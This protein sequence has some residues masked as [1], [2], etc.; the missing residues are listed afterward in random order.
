MYTAE[1][2]SGPLSEVPPLPQIAQAAGPQQNPYSASTPSMARRA[3]MAAISASAR[4]PLSQ[5][6]S[7]SPSI[8]SPYSGPSQMSPAPRHQL[9]Q[10]LQSTGY[11]PGSSFGVP[12]QAEEASQAGPA[13][14]EGPYMT[15]LPESLFHRGAQSGGQNPNIRFMPISTEHGP[16]YVPVDVQAA[17]KMA[18]EKRARNAGASARFRERRKQKEKEASMNIQKLEQQLRDLERRVRDAESDRDF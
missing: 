2:G 3:S 16:M 12:Q 5:S 18:D 15:S 10:S 13:G 6:A 8:K 11:F 4:T 14:T 17:S 7:P 1:P 9:A